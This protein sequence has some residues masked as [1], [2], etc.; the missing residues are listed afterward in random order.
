MDLRTCSSTTGNSCTKYCGGWARAVTAVP[1]RGARRAARRPAAQRTSS[2]RLACRWLLLWSVLPIA[3]SRLCTTRRCSIS[4]ARLVFR[5]ARIL[6]R[7]GIR[8]A[9]TPRDPP[10]PESFRGPRAE[11]NLPCRIRPRPA[12]RLPDGLGGR[13][14]L[15]EQGQVAGELENR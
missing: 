2:V 15:Q 1:Q 13:R 14:L 4:S 7:G 8:A 6:G 3:A 10:R 5:R 12:A 9:E 11:P